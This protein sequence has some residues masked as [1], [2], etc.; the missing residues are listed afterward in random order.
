MQI[1]EIDTFIDGAS[2]IVA[3]THEQQEYNNG[4]AQ[5]LLT[6]DLGLARISKDIVNSKN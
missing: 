6:P 4:E 3:A 2:Y 1:V 5:V